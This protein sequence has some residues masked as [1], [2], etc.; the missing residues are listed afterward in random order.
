MAGDIDLL[1]DLANGDVVAI[2]DVRHFGGHF[3]GAIGHL[4]PPLQRHLIGI[5]VSTLAFDVDVDGGDF[6]SLLENLPLQQV[7]PVMGLIQ[8]QCLVDLQMQVQ[9]QLSFNLV[10]QKVMDSQVAAASDS[11]NLLEQ[12]LLAGKMRLGVDQDIG[13]GKDLTDP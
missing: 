11:T 5:D 12:T 3:A 6:G 7:G 1:V 2:Q 13:A 9:S 4:A 8:V 10:N